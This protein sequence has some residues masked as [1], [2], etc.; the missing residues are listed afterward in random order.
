MPW[1]APEFVDNVPPARI[2][3]QRQRQHGPAVHAATSFPWLAIRERVEA[4][5]RRLAL[6]GGGLQRNQSS[7]SSSSSHSGTTRKSLRHNRTA[8]AAH[9]PTTAA[10]PRVAACLAG[11][12]RSFVHPAAGYSFERFVLGAAGRSTHIDTFVVI[13][14]GEE[15]HRARSNGLPLDEQSYVRSAEGARYLAAALARLRPVAVVTD[16]GVGTPSCRVAS[17]AQF[18]KLVRCVELASEHERARQWRYDLLLRTRPDVVWLSPVLSGGVTLGS[19]AATLASTPELRRTVLT[20]DDINLL[21]PRAAWDALMSMR[22]GSLRCA[23]LCSVR[24]WAWVAGVRTHCLMKAH[25]AAQNV[26]HVELQ[27]AARFEDVLHARSLP[28]FAPP[29]VAS[30]DGVAWERTQA[31]A[32]AGRGNLSSPMASL[33][34]SAMASSAAHAAPREQMLPAAELRV[35]SFEVLRAVL[36]SPRPPRRARSLGLAITCRASNASAGSLVAACSL[37]TTR[38]WLGRAAPLMHL[39][40]CDKTEGEGDCSARGRGRAKGAWEMGGAGERGGLLGASACIRRCEACERCH[41]VS[42]S[43]NHEDCSWF[44]RCALDKLQVPLG[45]ETFR[46]VQVRAPDGALAPP[47]SPPEGAPPCPDHPVT[48]WLPTASATASP[49]TRCSEAD[50]GGCGDLP[51]PPSAELAAHFEGLPSIRTILSHACRSAYYSTKAAAVEAGA[52][53]SAS[54]WP[55]PK[56]RSRRTAESAIPPLSAFPRLRNCSRTMNAVAS[57]AAYTALMRI[58]PT[59][60]LAGSVQGLREL[61]ALLA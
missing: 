18:D 60:P 26:H 29:L 5:L 23:K 2:D 21:A 31:A 6:R 41:F 48:A 54:P 44:H 16:T 17:T 57:S 53:T 22:S 24:F 50:A 9:H 10:A 37:C 8:A 42:F 19:L 55:P 7:S 51:P 59:R 45:A 12:A 40:F 28:E 27:G 3:A 56:K 25:F 32:G 35:G 61:E 1:P 34:V 4:R 20:T 39:G 52:E 11:A 13:G 30:F 43:T 33:M 49:P 38:D 14:T 36:P 47:T 15:D 46:T 58:S